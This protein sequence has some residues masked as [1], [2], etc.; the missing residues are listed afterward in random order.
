MNE[1]TEEISSSLEYK[2]ASEQTVI[3]LINSILKDKIY[4]TKNIESFFEQ[5]KEIVP[6]SADF[7]TTWLRGF[8]QIANFDFENAKKSY[9]QALENIDEGAKLKFKDFVHIFIQQG[10]ALF[11]YE[12]EKENAVLFCNLGVE[13]KLLAPVNESFFKN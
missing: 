9:L 11:M 4:K 8:Y 2:L 1:K 7:F 6:S 12:G 13:L 10:F 3:F 5:I